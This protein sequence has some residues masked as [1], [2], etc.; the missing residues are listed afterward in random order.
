MRLLALIL[1]IA[2]ILGLS[3]A[4][5]LQ[6]GSDAV[7]CTL[8]GLIKTPVSQDQNNTQANLEL[9]VGLLGA[10]NATYELVDSKDNI[11]KPSVY[12]SLQPGRTLLIFSVPNDALF[13]LL[14]VTPT[15][16]SPFNVNWWYTGKAIKG[17]LTLRYYGVVDWATQPDQQAI[18]LDVSLTNTGP[19]PVYLSPDNFTLLDQWG[20]PYYTMTGFAATQLAS[21]KSARVNIAFYGLS[22]FSRPTVLAYDY[23]TDNEIAIDLDKDLV[24]LTDAQIQGATA[25]QTSQTQT[26]Q[27]QQ[28]PQASQAAPA[29]QTT[30]APQTIQMP[31]VNEMPQT[32]QVPQF[33]QASQLGQESQFNQMLQTIKPAVKSTSYVTPPSNP[34]ETQGPSVAS[35]QT[36]TPSTQTSAPSGSTS[37]QSAKNQTT[38]ATMS[39]QDQIN[40]TK[41][42]LAGVKS[43]ITGGQSSVGQQISDSINETKK[44]L[45]AMTQG[46]QNTTKNQ[47]QNNSTTSP[48]QS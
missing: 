31:Q 11:Y 13:K 8:F 9:D 6:G 17:D 3:Q 21:G 26:A 2:L 38:N 41:Q 35:T 40:A 20:W 44:R 4:V 22:P 24:Q 12:K 43:G 19:T 29:P 27:T 34:P 30:Q 42:R 28:T 18:A 36:S 39:L 23:A 15:E 47:T 48:A 37:A 45:A 33:N 16:G 32:N 7:K 46:L 14:K 25:S 10:S 5:P 1:F